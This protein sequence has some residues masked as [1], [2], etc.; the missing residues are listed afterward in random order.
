M[1]GTVTRRE[2]LT[3]LVLG[4]GVLA[5]GLLGCVDL[6]HS[7]DFGA[8]AGSGCAV[9]AGG[10]GCADGAQGTDGPKKKDAGGD[11][12]TGPRDGGHPGDGGAH[13]GTVDHGGTGDGG[14]GVD[15]PA[16]S[17]GPGDAG[18]DAKVDTGTNF[19][20]FTSAEAKAAAQ[21]AC[22]WLGACAGNTGLNEYGTCYPIA[23]LAYDCSLNPDQ[24]VRAGALHAYWDALAH[25]TSC[26]DVMAA[27]FPAF[28]P[29]CTNPVASCG[30]DLAGGALLG[31]VV[32]ICGDGGFTSAVN[33]QMLGY[34]C[35]AGTCTNGG[36]A[37]TAPSAGCVGPSGNILHAC[38]NVENAAGT[39]VAL[40][41]VGRD[42]TNFG[43]GKCVADASSG[44]YG[45]VPNAGAACTPS[46]AVTCVNGVVTACATGTFETIQCAGFD[47][48]TKCNPDGGWAASSRDL[49][50]GCYNS[51]SI[52][53]GQG[54]CLGSGGF[55]DV[56]GPAGAVTVGC[57]DAGFAACAINPVTG[58]PYCPKP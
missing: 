49:A 16:D 40:V 55:E 47:P 14:H 56:A 17:P 54:D 3:W 8:G 21:R 53:G 19:C 42:C 58:E 34:T 38:Q 33:C 25:A 23:L 2:R 57:L 31:D 30:T 51:A 50:G 11:G 39:G 10:S 32:T 12:Q 13:D 15:A 22:L 28:V 6:F 48:T 29:L 41:D 20:S 36:A 24:E 43:A 44:A 52:G 9:E 26:G 45:C 4:G 1:R 37:C 18:H 46:A 7:T 5:V 27:I 35:S